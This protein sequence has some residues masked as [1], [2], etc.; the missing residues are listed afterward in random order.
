L[1][2][3]E[4]FT[5]FRRSLLAARSALRRRLWRSAPVIVAPS[6]RPQALQPA[7]PKAA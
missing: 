5:E 1:H 3:L 6:W 2:H 4:H 7:D